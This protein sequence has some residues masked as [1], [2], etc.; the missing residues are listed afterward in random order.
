MLPNEGP[1]DGGHNQTYMKTYIFIPHNGSCC[2]PSC[3]CLHFPHIW[4][5]RPTCV[6]S[7]ATAN[8]RCIFSSP[9]IRCY[10]RVLLLYTLPFVASFFI[11][12]CNPPIL[13]ISHQLLFSQL[14]LWADWIHILMP[15]LLA[16]LL[17][18]DWYYS[19][20]DWCWWVEDHCCF[21]SNL[22][23]Y[24]TSGLASLLPTMILGYTVFGIN[25]FDCCEWTV[26]HNLCFGYCYLAAIFAILVHRQ[27][28]YNTSCFSRT[29]DNHDSIVTDKPMIWFNQPCLFNLAI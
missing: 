29:G 28:H 22:V 27:H 16:V 19:N 21:F 17:P 13:V 9:S 3:D 25:M 14:S 2:T 18:I 23:W 12:F 20:Q 15:V 26:L 11:H 10:T 8:P 7:S 5:I 1:K 4:I 24:I 6:P